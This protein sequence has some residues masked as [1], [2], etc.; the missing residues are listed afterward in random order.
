[1][2]AWLVGRSRA[3]FKASAGRSRLSPAGRVQG[4]L[5]EVTLGRRSRLCLVQEAAEEGAFLK[6]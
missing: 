6:K 4:D 1:M 5:L 2:S 3:G